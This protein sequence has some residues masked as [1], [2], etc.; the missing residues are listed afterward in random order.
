MPAGTLIFVAVDANPCRSGVVAWNPQLELHDA[1]DALLIGVN[2]TNSG[3]TCGA[4]TPVCASQSGLTATAPSSAAEALVWRARTTGTYYAKVFQ[5]A[6]S[7]GDYLVSISLSSDH[8]PTA[9]DSSISGQVV[10]TTGGPLA[11]V[12]INLSGTESR[13]AITDS[14]GKYSFDSVETNGLYTVTPS[15]ANYSF[16][17]ASRSFSLLGVHAEASFTATANGDQTNAIDTTE[18]FVRQHYLDFLA[19]EPDPPGFIGWVNTL[20]NCTT[21]DSSCDRVH[22]SEMFYR[23][24]EF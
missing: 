5:G 21:G 19:R 20:R 4:A 12:T 16:S 10:D 15:R 14:N 17:P 18:F 1:A 8:G 7:T 9:A 23:S 6:A 3:L 22:V 13:E 11:G 2:D 24:Q